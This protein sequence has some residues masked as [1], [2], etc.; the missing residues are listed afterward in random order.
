MSISEQAGNLYVAGKASKPALNVEEM[1]VDFLKGGQLTGLVPSD[2]LG[3]ILP[4]YG[5]AEGDCLDS[6]MDLSNFL[7]QVRQ[8]SHETT[9]V[10][11]SLFTQM[12]LLD[13]SVTT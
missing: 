11:S 6:F 1:D 4:E 2:D 8:Y 5:L 3:A 12:F 7:L 9:L 13:F 10:E